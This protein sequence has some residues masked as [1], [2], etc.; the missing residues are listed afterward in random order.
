M[1]KEIPIHRDIFG[2][3]ILEGSAVAFSYRNSLHIGTVGKCTSKMVR[4]HSLTRSRR[5][6]PKG[7]LKYASELVTVS[8]P[9]V[10]MY[11]LRNSGKS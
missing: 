4:V 8:G 11:I 5:Q 1:K 10:T 2:R 9:D 3:E 6:N 7:Y